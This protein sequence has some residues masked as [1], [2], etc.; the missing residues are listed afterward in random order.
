FYQISY[1]S[2]KDY[3]RHATYF[4]DSGA[5]LLA[6]EISGADSP[7]LLAAHERFLRIIATYT[8]L[9]LR[10]L[11][12]AAQ[13]LGTALWAPKVMAQAERSAALRAAREARRNRPRRRTRPNY[14]VVA[15]ITAFVTLLATPIVAGWRLQG[16]QPSYYNAIAARAL[17]R[18]LLFTDMLAKPDGRWPIKAP[19]GGHDPSYTYQGGGYQIGGGPANDIAYATLSTTG[20]DPATYGD[21][22][23]EVT[24]RES[25]SSDAGG[26]G[27]ILR[28]V[29]S[30]ANE[31]FVDFWVSTDG[32]W[33]LERF[34]GDAS[35]PNGW[36]YLASSDEYSSGSPVHAGPGATN[37]ILVVMRGD[38]IICFVNGQFVTAARDSGIPASGRVGVYL[39]DS[40]DTGIFNDFSVY[41]AA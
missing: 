37:I 35:D 17:A 9:T 4:L 10:D 20:G 5:T 22:A 13:E 1:R 18:G 3:T 8:C 27:L 34:A 14:A 23:I 30:G 26:V 38:E 11:S 39:N 36:A 32:G 24:A 41:P 33:S 16:I 7:E 6:W 25:G 2:L 19:D 40:A 21:A 28:D 29:K 15:G 31:D 12:N